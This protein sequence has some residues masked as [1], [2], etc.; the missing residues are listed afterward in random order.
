MVS[1][2]HPT[3]QAL[4][5]GTTIIIEGLSI[6]L[7]RSGMHIFYPSSTSESPRLTL[8]RLRLRA[9][10][11]FGVGCNLRAAV[12]IYILI[13]SAQRAPSPISDASQHVTA[14]TLFSSVR[15][16]SS[17][18]HGPYPTDLRALRYNDFLMVH[19]AY[20]FSCQERLNAQ[21]IDTYISCRSTLTRGCQA[22]RGG[23][24]VGYLH[25]FRVGRGNDGHIR[26]VT[27]VDTGAW[28]SNTRGQFQPI[29]SGL[30]TA[31]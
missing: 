4:Q 8:Q 29:A 27:C 22:W 3:I 23:S 28:S 26:S 12:S 5:L 18:L 7:V 15:R 1:S 2:E 30:C 11:L 9:L 6:M 16:S 10:S 25:V 31:C 13:D 21:H 17:A 14:A 20:M 19:R 24:W